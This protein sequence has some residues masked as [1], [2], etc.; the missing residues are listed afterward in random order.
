M[1]EKFIRVLKV[2][3]NKPPEEVTLK[4]DLADL[5]TTVGGLI[6]FLSLDSSK[7]IDL[8][9]N[10]E[11]KLIGLEPNRRIGDDVIVGT[12]YILKCN[13]NGESCSLN[14]EDIAIYKKRFAEPEH[15]TKEEV[16]ATLR[17]GFKFV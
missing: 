7:G 14:D 5:Q 2:E 3:P 4:N 8:M 1:K 11:G 6:E 10:E 13:R 15:I 12:F 16:E 17:F 9:C